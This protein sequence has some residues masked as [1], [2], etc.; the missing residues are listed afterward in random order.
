MEQKLYFFI[1]N[2]TFA[3]SLEFNFSLKGEKFPNK[4]VRVLSSCPEKK[5]HE[6]ETI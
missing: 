5:K 1:K 4:C 6:K 2:I 3:P